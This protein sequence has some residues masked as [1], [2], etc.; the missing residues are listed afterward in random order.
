MISFASQLSTAPKLLDETPHSLYNICYYVLDER[1]NLSLADGD[2][3]QW[4]NKHAQFT[5]NK[6]PQQ[7]WYNKNRLSVGE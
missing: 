3:K 7:H 1:S 2:H 5:A 4:F 6:S